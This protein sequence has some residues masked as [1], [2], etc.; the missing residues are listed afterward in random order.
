MTLAEI[1]EAYEARRREQLAGR[2]V[3]TP[4]GHAVVARTGWPAPWS[5]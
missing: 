3:L 1:I 2:P 5:R 4:L